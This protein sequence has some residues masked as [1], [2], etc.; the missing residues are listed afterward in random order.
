M[1]TTD[2]S[3]V[4]LLTCKMSK[5]SQLEIV[6]PSLPK[7][8]PD[9]SVYYGSRMASTDMTRSM[10]KVF[11]AEKVRERVSARVRLAGLSER[12]FATP[13]PK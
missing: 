13:H 11:G 1:G 7:S 3:P 12:F 9:N 6:V 10:E 5:S 8:G 2:N 4:I